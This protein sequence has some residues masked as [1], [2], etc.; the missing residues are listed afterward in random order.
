MF[1]KKYVVM[2]MI[3]HD[4]AVYF[5][6]TLSSVEEK[7][8]LSHFAIPGC[9]LAT[10]LHGHSEGGNDNIHATKVAVQNGRPVFLKRSIHQVGLESSTA[11]DGED[12]GNA[13]KRLT[14]EIGT[15]V[16]R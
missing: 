6:N 5:R 15:P 3:R 8:K 14:K 13:W 11:V 10:T 9:V 2:I 7:G 4:E 1:N 16:S 12:T